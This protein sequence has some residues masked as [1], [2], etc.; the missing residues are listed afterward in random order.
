[1]YSVEYLCIYILLSDPPQH[2]NSNA[3]W[4]RYHT[5]SLFHVIAALQIRVGYVL[6]TKLHPISG[7]T[8][9]TQPERTQR[10]LNCE[11]K[12]GA[13]CFLFFSRCSFLFSSFFSFL[14]LLFSSRPSFLFSP[15]F[16]LLAL[17]FFS[18]P[19]WCQMGM[20]GA[21][22]PPEKESNQQDAIRLAAGMRVMWTGASWVLPIGRSVFRSR[23][24]VGERLPRVDCWVVWVQGAIVS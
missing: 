5:R 20:K 15:F 3:E 4:G 12:R 9:E 11:E 23:L 21:H 2:I 16:S 17:L 24:A 19:F 13:G 10:G 7:R 14:T 18:H 22:I 1:V 6:A 8:S